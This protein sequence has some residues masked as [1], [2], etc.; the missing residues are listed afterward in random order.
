VV[1]R[2]AI[3]LPELPVGR[4]AIVA[5]VDEALPELMEIGFVPGAHV[6]PRHSG[7][8]GDPRVY[9]VDGAL[10][11]LRRTA[12]RRVQVLAAPEGMEGKD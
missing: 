11:A 6:R 7:V 8:G 5:T 12:A 10:V 4:A 9:E 3:P 2:K 1:Q